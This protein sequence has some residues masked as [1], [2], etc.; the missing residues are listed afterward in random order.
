[1]GAFAAP[2]NA[3][4]NTT[5]ERAFHAQV[6]DALEGLCDVSS[7]QGK[8]FRV[9]DEPPPAMGRGCAK[10]VEEWAESDAIERALA[11]CEELPNPQLFFAPHASGVY[12]TY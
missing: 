7:P 4:L 2:G 1:M 3:W 10:V 5:G 11:S 12:A 9:F 6:E 8:S